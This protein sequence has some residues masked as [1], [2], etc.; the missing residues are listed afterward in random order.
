MH[1]HLGQTRAR[2]P[3]TLPTKYR[4]TLHAAKIAKSHFKS[5]QI[6]FGNAQVAAAY[7]TPLLDALQQYAQRQTTP[8]HIPGHKQGEGILSA[9]A[10]ILGSKA[11]KMDLTELPGAVLLETLSHC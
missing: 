8:F 6:S 5:N 11:L 4:N 2:L 3:F 10:A 1:S 7:A 9:F